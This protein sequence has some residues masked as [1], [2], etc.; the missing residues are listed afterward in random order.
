M[1]IIVLAILATVG[2]YFLLGIDGTRSNQLRFRK[3]RIQA[4]APLFG[5]L[6]LLTGMFAT[7]RGNEVGIVYNPFKGG[8]Q[9]ESLPEGLH[10][11][12]PWVEVYTIRTV[13]REANYEM[14]VQTGKIIREISPGV[15]EETGGGQWANYDV[16]LQYRIEVVN[17]HR[18]YRNF[19]GDVAD[20]STLEARVRAALQE[21]SV[22]YDIFSLLKGDIV[23][24]RQL[25]KEDLDE[26]LSPLGIT[27]ES[28]IIRDI[29]AGLV[30]EQVIEAEAVAAKQREIAIKE[31]E[32]AL[33]RQETKRLE[34]EIEALRVVI[35]ATAIAEAEELIRSVTTNAIRTMYLGQF[36][37]G[38]DQATPDVYGYL[39][40][41]EVAEIVLKQLYYDTWDGKLPDVIAGDGTG[42]IINP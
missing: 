30:I 26:S 7:V 13:L 39:T 21:N 19:G 15:F 20:S 8:I 29:D 10:I 12:A 42:I 34:A 36:Q 32:A 9:D 2:G 17:A 35:E 27:V 14:S 31:Q 25:T 4:L 38:E 6:V 24:V 33:I 37:E 3:R 1:V 22:K 40:I 5:V 23:L 28:F 11:K 18:F 16:T 41:Q